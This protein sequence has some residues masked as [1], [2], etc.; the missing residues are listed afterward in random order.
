MED[1]LLGRRNRH[2]GP[3]VS[4]RTTDHHER[5]RFDH[6]RNRGGF[7]QDSEFRPLKANKKTGNIAQESEGHFF[8]SL[9]RR[10]MQQRQS[11]EDT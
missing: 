6:K 4:D 3:N 11:F 10:I 2:A 5:L 1:H 8:V 7:F 9:S